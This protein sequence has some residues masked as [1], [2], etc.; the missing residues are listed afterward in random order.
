[1][2]RPGTFKARTRPSVNVFMWFTK[3]KTFRAARIAGRTNFPDD[4]FLEVPETTA[5][6]PATE[7]S[8]KRSAPNFRRGSSAG[9]FF[10]EGVP[11]LTTI[12]LRILA[13]TL[14]LTALL[15]P[16][17]FAQTAA[18]SGW[19]P[20]FNGVNF[21]GLYVYAVGTGVINIATDSSVVRL[22]GQTY[23]NAF[24]RV[25][26]GMIRV[27]G[28]GTVNGYI[29]TIRQ[30][31]HYRA[32]VQYKWPTNTSSTA[33]A[34]M[35]VHIDSAQVRSAGYNNSNNRPRSI[36]VN[37]K[38]DQNHP[39]SIW[40]ASNLGPS[41][42]AYVQDSSIA[43]PLW[44]PTGGIRWVINPAN[45]RTLASSLTNPELPLGQWNTGVYELRGADSGAF[46][47]N[48]QTRLRIYDF[49]ASTT[50]TGH[51]AA[52]KYGRG[53]IVLQTEGARIH[54][55]NFEVQELDSITGIPIY[56]TTAI[57]AAL[58]RGAGRSDLWAG[59]AVAGGS[60]WVTVPEHAAG[61]ELYDLSGRKVW[62]QRLDRGAERGLET[63]ISLPAHLG[64]GVLRVRYLD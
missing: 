38:R 20:L 29:G 49:R 50:S 17:G 2:P 62:S 23:D 11:M 30:Y 10:S 24:F 59:F 43:I 9:R 34:G 57:K 19:R 64:T 42:V 6:I 1:M 25:D 22:S 47:L 40:A 41:M 26:T 15:A 27:Q 12:R 36:E 16:S 56:A 39:M 3:E 33:N 35:L 4:I 53:N 37:M 55:R 8:A 31:S 52:A 32:R 45:K 58:W 7:I 63:R 61:F 21:N 48:G 54:Y 28:S 18:D 46:T 44:A 5:R 60:G 14:A 51:N 13:G